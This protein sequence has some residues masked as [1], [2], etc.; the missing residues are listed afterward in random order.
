MT[1]QFTASAYVWIEDEVIRHSVHEK[2]KSLG[3]CTYLH[4]AEETDDYLFIS[5]KRGKIFTS[6]AGGSNIFIDCGTDTDLFLEL[7]QMRSDTDK[8]QWFTNGR[9]WY[10][11]VG[12]N[13]EFEAIKHLS[14]CRRATPREI[15]EHLKK[16]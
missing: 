1:L 8:G 9:D 16:R 14:T 11:H 6:S 2:L 10:R 7:A 5:G 12:D 4:T 3:W 13:G 15:Y